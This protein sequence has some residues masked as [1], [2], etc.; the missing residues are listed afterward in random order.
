MTEVNGAAVVADLDKMISRIAELEAENK[1]LWAFVRAN[2]YWEE[3]IWWGTGEFDIFKE[4][5]R[6]RLREALRQYEEK[7]FTYDP[8]APLKLA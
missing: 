5:E 4:G 7:P 1:A 6:Q 3:T 2:E 8:D